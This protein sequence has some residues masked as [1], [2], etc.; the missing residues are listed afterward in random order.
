MVPFHHPSFTNDVVG[1][2]FILRHSCVYGYSQIIPSLAMNHGAMY[3]EYACP[4]R[5]TIGAEDR[6]NFQSFILLLTEGPKHD[7]KIAGHDSR[8][9]IG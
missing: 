9:N 4:Y 6:L 7:H 1:N 2:K 3:I 8:I 5:I